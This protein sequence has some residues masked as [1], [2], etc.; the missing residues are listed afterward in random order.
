MKKLVIVF[1]LLFGTFFLWT[2][3]GCNEEMKDC[4]CY[5]SYTGTGSQNYTNSNYDTQVDENNHCD[6]LNT[7]ETDS[8]GLTKTVSCVGNY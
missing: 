1:G 6:G 5:V 3:S 7:S 2:I 4:T 8:N